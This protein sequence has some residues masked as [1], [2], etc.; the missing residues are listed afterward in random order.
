MAIADAVKRKIGRELVEWIYLG[1]KAGARRSVSEYERLKATDTATAMAHLRRAVNMPTRARVRIDAAR[2][3]Y[4]ARNGAGAFPAFARSC[5]QLAGTITLTDLN[6]ALA[7]LEAEAAGWKAGFR[8]GTLSADE[9][10]AQISAAWPD[11]SS[12]WTFP[13][14]SSYDDQW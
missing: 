5:L 9:V 14:P 11:D 13:I 12:E 6:S 7:D 8:A 4:E 2:D 10:A 1:V 3:R